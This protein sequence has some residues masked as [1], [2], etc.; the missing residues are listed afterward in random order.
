MQKGFALEIARCSGD[1]QD[2]GTLTYYALKFGRGWINPIHFKRLP[3][4][5]IHKLAQISAPI[6]PRFGSIRTFGLR[7]RVGCQRG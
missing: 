4:S 6:S 5:Q 2:F 3:R 1:C 7:R